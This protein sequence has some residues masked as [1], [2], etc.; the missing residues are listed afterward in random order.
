MKGLSNSY[1]TD[2]LA[3]PQARALLEKAVG[4]DVLE[5]VANAGRAVVE[6]IAQP[7]AVIEDTTKDIPPVVDEDMLQAATSY[8]F[9]PEESA[10]DAERGWLVRQA[11]MVSVGA[12]RLLRLYNSERR[13][14]LDAP[15]ATSLLPLLLAAREVADRATL[16]AKTVDFDRL[17]DAYL[18]EFLR[19]NFSSAASQLPA[20]HQRAAVAAREALDGIGRLP[21]AAPSLADF[22]RQ[23]NLAEILAPLGVIIGIADDAPV[24]SKDRFVGRSDQLATLRGVVDELRSETLLEGL[25]RSVQR[26][27]RRKPRL[28]TIKARG[29]LGKTALVAKFLYD[30]AT[31]PGERFPFAYLDFDRSDIQPRAGGLLLLEICRQLACQYGEEESA[32]AD[33]SDQIR[34]VLAGRATGSLTSWCKT[35]RVIVRQIISRSSHS[36][37]FLLVLDTLEI[38][39][40]D[41]DAM[42]GVVSLVRTLVEEPFIELCLVAAGRSGFEEFLEIEAFEVTPVVLPPFSLED[43]RAMIS[44]L[45]IDLLQSE[46]KSNWANRL[47]GRKTDPAVR[48]EPLSLRL[49]VELVRNADPAQ[50]DKVVADIERDGE[51]ADQAFVARLY[52]RRI[53]DHVRD[54]HAQKL[55]WPG[56]VAR[57]VTLDMAKNVLAPICGLTPDE[58]EAAFAILGR[59]G[60]IVDVEDG[61]R[62]LRHRRDLRARTLPLMRRHNPE[63]FN[64]VSDALIDYYGQSQTADAIEHAYYT[65]LRSEDDKLFSTVV[66]PTILAE[67]YG[68]LDDFEVGSSAW[69]LLQAR[70]GRRPLELEPMRRLPDELVWDHLGRTGSGLRGVNDRKIEPRTAMLMHRG[71]PATNELAAMGPWQA[72]QIKCGLWNNLTPSNLTVP[73]SQYD[74]TLFAF[75]IAQLSLAGEVAPDFWA[76]RYPILI[77]RLYSA[78]GTDNWH[79]L[80]FSLTAAKL[81]DPV[82][83]A[84]IDRR[85][86][87][88][89]EGA[90]GQGRLR[91]ISLRTLLALGDESR[92]P[93]LS[94]WCVAE[95]DRIS[96]GISFAEFAAL[97]WATDYEVAAHNFPAAEKLM[98]SAHAFRTSSAARDIATLPRVFHKEKQV[99]LYAGEMIRAIGSSADARRVKAFGGLYGRIREPE[100]I[101]PFAYLLNGSL[102]PDWKARLLESRS[103]QINSSDRDGLFNPLQTLLRRPVW[104]DDMVVL[105]TAADRAGDFEGILSHLQP[106]LRDGEADAVSKLQGIRQLARRRFSELAN[107]SSANNFLLETPSQGPA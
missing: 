45:G 52:E 105:L 62:T 79:A 68:D 40:A 78:R 1:L 76:K 97:A 17:V 64:K 95:P 22:R 91:D 6:Q 86:V 39:D 9:N 63:L 96:S 88:S 80:T 71:P 55:A 32:L 49:A 102:R 3:N 56:L 65:L 12:R 25:R 38:V 82:L 36:A 30:H 104:P 103:P 90:S 54:K 8:N 58:A 60:W 83:A 18:R 21:P 33:L 99:V 77:E 16:A 2:L 106:L 48:R 84:H 44:R 57:R 47:A 26:L 13:R 5:A 89:L 14:I 74:L 43:A 100:W 59:E 94:A 50:R 81:Y 15:E 10:D 24:G 41:P 61:G 31:K 51:K 87:S 53:L 4:R 19:G 23:A 69:V 101:I 107:A 29:G 98:E 73:L 35:F 11:K 28:L 93:A 92:M 7:E 85:I 70:C 67:L 37:T 42:L 34:N 66:E 20:L 75:Y 46:W 72:I 27:V